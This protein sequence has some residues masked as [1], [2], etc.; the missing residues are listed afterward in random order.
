M[1]IYLRI[2]VKKQT[3]ELFEK[4]YAEFFKHHPDMK[5]MTMTEDFM[6]NCICNYYLYND[7]LI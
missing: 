6:I 5:S 7:S 2:Y 1:V 3:K 4:C